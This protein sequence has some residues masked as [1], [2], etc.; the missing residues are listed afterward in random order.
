MT[1]LDLLT[2]LEDV[3]K[4]ASTVPLTGKIMVDASEVQEIIDD[5][6][7]C[8]PD[9]VKHAQWVK[10]ERDKILVEAKKEYKR[11]ISEAQKQADYMVDNDDITLKA[12]KYANAI[13]EAADDYSRELKMRTYDYLDKMLFDMQ[14]KM[15]S[16]N[17]KYLKEIY[18]TMEKT[19][20]GIDEELQVNRDELK[21]MAIRTRNGEEW[22]EAYEGQ[23]AAEAE[24]EEN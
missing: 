5:I 6:R 1:V 3:I 16:L 7:A 10:E 18:D 13:G 20:V 9:D 12:R 2:E 19:F 4:T 17:E 23:P 21:D 14:A 24:T 8:L 11:L 15:T 22:L